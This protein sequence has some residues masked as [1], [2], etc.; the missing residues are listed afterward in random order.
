[1]M[2]N[3]PSSAAALNRYRRRLAYFSGSPSSFPIAAIPMIVPTGCGDGGS[4]KSW[5]VGAAQQRV[6]AAKQRGNTRVG[7]IAAQYF[8]ESAREVRWLPTAAY[9][10]E[11]CVW[12]PC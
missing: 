11:E 2:W 7:R 3:V 12:P 4:V 6:T 8:T 9:S 10:D 1:M 5:T